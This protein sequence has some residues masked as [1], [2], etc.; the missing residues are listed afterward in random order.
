MSAADSLATPEQAA[1]AYKTSVGYIYKM[2][3]LH[4]WRRLRHDGQVY[5]HWDDVSK[6][7]GT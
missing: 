2:A 7:L 1:K 4:K 6:T 5:Y 3:S